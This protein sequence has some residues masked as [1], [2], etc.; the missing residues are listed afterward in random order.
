M[1]AKYDGNKKII[2][3]SG[4]GISAESGI[5]TFR[6]TN[7]L[8]EKHRIEEICTE[9]TWK[10]NFE[11]VHTFYNQRRIQLNQV[12]PNKAHETV[13]TL[14]KIYGADCYVITQ[15]VD[16]LFERAGCEDVLH[17]H[18]E[19]Q[20]MECTACGNIWDIGHNIFDIEK[21][22]CPKCNS[23]KGVKPY[24]VFFGGFASK[25]REMYRAFEAAKHKDSIVVIIGTMGN[26]INIEN[27]LENK[28][29]KKILNNLEPSDY[30]DD[31]LF[32][33]VYYD[34]A[35]K[36]LTKIE[37]DIQYFWENIH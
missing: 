17:V 3:F 37:E 2:I 16:D 11:A 35:T 14:K 32:D 30:I 27:L 23:L 15:N 9:N 29:S 20:K 8:W 24:I 25:Y 36:A 6:D 5:N 19:L 21:D 18:G 10:Q 4:A 7:G 12:K 28:L 26:V 31:T 33:K 22:R 34:K 1:I 13:A